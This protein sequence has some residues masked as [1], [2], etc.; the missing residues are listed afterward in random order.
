M[1]NLTGDINK[2]IAILNRRIEHL[3]TLES[4]ML[5]ARGI[6]C[7]HIAP[8]VEG[9]G[10]CNGDFEC[11]PTREYPLCQDWIPENDY[12]TRVT[13]GLSGNWRIMGGQVGTGAGGYVLS[14]KFQ[15]VDENREYYLTAAFIATDAAATVDFGVYCYDAAKVFIGSIWPLDGWAPGQDWDRR[16]LDIG[17]VG[18]TK[19]LGGTRYAKVISNLQTNAA[20]TDA[21]CYIDHVRFHEL[22]KTYSPLIRLMDDWTIDDT[23]RDFTVGVSIY[24]T[25]TLT[26]TLE[27]PG[28]IW[29]TYHLSSHRNIT[30][31]RA[32]SHTFWPTIGGAAISVYGS[33]FGQSVVND[34]H[35]LDITGRTQN[36]L[37]RGVYNLDLRIQVMNA[38]DTVQCQY[39]I[40]T[41]FYTRAW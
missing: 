19:W 26:L 7:Q 31:A 25:S 22:D 12:V 20:L 33:T 27:E 21:W 23:L 9:K 10:I 24:P 41:A 6:G 30:N 32:F 36:I 14:D 13:G 35:D 2:D 39:L 40:G 4:Y 37:A 16:Q 34:Y 8:P 18:D 11:G 15:P 1:R 17:P 28:Y 3:E 29:F 5:W 38:A